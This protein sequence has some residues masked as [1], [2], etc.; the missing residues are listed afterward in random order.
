[1]FWF[2]PALHT[3]VMSVQADACA[4]IQCLT[5]F[6]F[7]SF[8]LNGRGKG[9]YEPVTCFMRCD[10]QLIL[11]PLRVI[12][13]TMLWELQ[14]LA[15][16]MWYHRKPVMSLYKL[17]SYSFSSYFPFQIK[18]P[19]V[20]NDLLFFCNVLTLLKFLTKFGYDVFVELFGI[21]FLTWR[22]E[23]H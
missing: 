3:I 22:T 19:L 11:P 17:T 15:D 18:I 12:C 7:I 14:I 9:W 4:P 16:F 1:M 13:V 23:I 20:I 6:F 10:P 8:G 2:C 21:C 5:T